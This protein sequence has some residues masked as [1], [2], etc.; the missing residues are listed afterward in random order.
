VKSEWHR[1]G[2][3]EMTKKA[4]IMEL[5]HQDGELE[6]ALKELEKEGLVIASGQSWDPYSRRMKTIYKSVIEE[7]TV[8]EIPRPTKPKNH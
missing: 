2:E 3:S 8:C 7:Q 5:R 6:T 4:W 1:E